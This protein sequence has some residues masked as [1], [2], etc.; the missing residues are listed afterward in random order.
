MSLDPF[1]DLSDDGCPFTELTRGA[2]WN[3]QDCCFLNGPKK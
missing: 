1:S 3:N 2:R